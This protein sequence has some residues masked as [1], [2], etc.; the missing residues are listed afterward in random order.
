MQK[1]CS[2]L[3]YCLLV[4]GAAVLLGLAFA[5][6]ARATAIALLA[7]WL[8]G[9]LCEYAV[10][11]FV[12]HGPRLA[13]RVHALHHES[14]GCEHIDPFSYFG[15]IAVAVAAWYAVYAVSRDIAGAHG[16]AAGLC[17]QYSFFRAVH[18]RLHVALHR[19]ASGALA[20]YHDGHHRE[21]TANFG[22]TTR[23]W[24]RLFGTQHVVSENSRDSRFGSTTR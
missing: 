16:F 19:G 24:D 14:P 10:H 4:G 23:V 2:S 3:H 21:Q 13:A 8:A 15:P 5:S 22:V 7:G 18:R 17:L 12:L 11:R 1:T 20:N 9:S 6:D